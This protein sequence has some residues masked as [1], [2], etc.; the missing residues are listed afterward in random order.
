MNLATQLFTV[1]VATIICTRFF[2]YVLPIPS[3]SLGSLRLHHYMYGLILAPLGIL[4]DNPP[5]FAV[6]LGLF[7]DE[8]GYLLIGG[9]THKDNYSKY[10]LILL[11]IFASLI[12]IFRGELTL[13]FRITFLQ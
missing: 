1:F 6:G 12:Y 13:L 10:S 4:F 2:L 8:L 9:K 5:L 11:G 7:V 3:P